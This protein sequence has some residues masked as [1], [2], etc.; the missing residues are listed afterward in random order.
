MKVVI[1]SKNSDKI[2]ILKNAL[3]EL[4][5]KFTIDG[6]DVDSGITK[7][8]LDKKTTKKGAA[9]RARNAFKA[10]PDSDLAFGLEGGLYDYGEGYHLVTFA[11]LIDKNGKKHF[12]QGEEI[13]LPEEVSEKVKSGGWFGDVIREYAKGP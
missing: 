1:G 11:C 8:P 7:Q 3:R 12:G 9:N 5:L 6:V 10:S 4:H 13:H 2:K